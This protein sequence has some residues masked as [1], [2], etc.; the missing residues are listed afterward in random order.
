MFA[1][2]FHR[3]LVKPATGALGPIIVATTRG[4]VITAA[5]GNRLAHHLFIKL[6]I[7]RDAY[8]SRYI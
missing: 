8:A 5:A 6:T 7:D 4:A 3:R 2:G 1:I